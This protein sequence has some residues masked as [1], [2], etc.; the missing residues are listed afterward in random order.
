MKCGFVR[1]FPLWNLRNLRI[2]LGVLTVRWLRFFFAASLPVAGAAIVFFA[3]RSWEVSRL[4]AQ[5]EQ[6]QQQREHLVEYVR[7][8]KASRRVA[9]ADVLQQ[10]PDERGRTVS[11]IRWNEIGLDGT[12]GEPQ[13]IEAVGR[14]VYFEAAVIKFDLDR[15]GEGDPEKG[16]SLA[17]FRRVFGED[18]SASSVS[19]I[20][21]QARAPSPDRGT[22]NANEQKMWSLFWRLMDEPPLAEQFGVRVAQC[23]APAVVLQSGQIWEVTLDA[24]G[25]LNL[26]LVAQRSVSDPA[27]SVAANR[28]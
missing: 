3:M 13:T 25:G 20:D 28:R 18:Q 1:I 17:L 2:T 7:R 19:D 5:V 6:L 12:L 27:A 22:A 4:T 16:V 11:V 23:E 15:V 8:L 9:Q 24:A 26:R 10:F 14:L 21:R